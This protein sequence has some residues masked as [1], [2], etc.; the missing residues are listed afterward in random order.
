MNAILGKINGEQ[1]P[2]RKIQNVISNPIAPASTS[3]SIKPVGQSTL[4]TIEQAP[5]DKAV[6]YVPLRPTLIPGTVNLEDG[7]EIPIRKF[8]TEAI[9]IKNSN[10]DPLIKESCQRVILKLYE[11][12]QEVA[13]NCTSHASRQIRQ[14]SV[15]LDQLNLKKTQELRDEATEIAKDST[16]SALSNTCKYFISTSTIVIGG[17]FVG[18]GSAAT[19]G[20]FLIASG[21]LGLLNRTAKDTNAY[22]GLASYFTKSKEMQEKIASTITSSILFATIGL[23]FTGGIMS[24]FSSGIEAAN[25]SM[26]AVEAARNVEVAI[27]ITSAGIGIGKANSDK[28]TA[29]IQKSLKHIEGRI[30]LMKQDLQRWGSDAKNTISMIQA[31][32]AQTKQAI[33]AFQ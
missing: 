29:Q 5:V 15:E 3:P 1:L 4:S 6:N 24:F 27:G 7:E 10:A 33:E 30:F 21:G 25:S 26:A 12:V 17:I 31:V 8:L 20:G 16:W 9:A 13:T 28:N 11:L 18:T 19:A 22:Q 32:T 14:G 23:G 2:L